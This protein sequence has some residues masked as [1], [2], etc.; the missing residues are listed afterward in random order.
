MT[1]IDFNLGCTLTVGA[2]TKALGSASDGRV[3]YAY[4]ANG[5][6]VVLADSDPFINAMLEPGDNEERLVKNLLGHFAGP[7]E[8][9]TPDPPIEITIDVKPD[10]ANNP[11]NPKS[12]GVVKVAILTTSVESGDSIDFD[13]WESV[14]P[15]TIAFGP[16]NAASQSESASDVDLDG[17]LDML[18]T[19]LT[20]EIGVQCGMTELE[21]TAMTYEGA[22]LFGSDSITTPGCK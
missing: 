9:P 12:N 11:I 4:G 6:V 14:D 20:Q 21:L 10:T 19:F 8:T 1:A 3:G 13:P 5:A 7:D 22:S 18:L 15:S 16:G 2:G 17:D